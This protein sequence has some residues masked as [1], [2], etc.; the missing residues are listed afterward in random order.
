[1]PHEKVTIDTLQFN[2]YSST[3]NTSSVAFAYTAIFH[4]RQLM[5]RKLTLYAYG[6]FLCRHAVK[7]TVALRTVSAVRNL[8]LQMW[9]LSYLACWGWMLC[10]LEAGHTVWDDGC[11]YQRSRWKRDQDEEDQSCDVRY[12]SSSPSIISSVNTAVR[13]RA[14]SLC[15]PATKLFTIKKNS[16]DRYGS[17]SYGQRHCQSLTYTIVLK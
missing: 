7:C 13:W 5:T 16:K 17:Q 6:I 1:M 10:R 12:T 9:F 3:L 4:S 11:C 2:E 8:A 15:A 14:L